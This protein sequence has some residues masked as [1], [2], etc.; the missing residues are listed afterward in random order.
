MLTAKL[1]ILAVLQRSVAVESDYTEKDSKWRE[2][3]GSV[4]A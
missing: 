1:S 4:I 2:K 3:E